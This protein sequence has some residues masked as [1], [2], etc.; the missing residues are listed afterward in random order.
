MN[1]RPGLFRL[2]MIGAAL[3]VIAVTSINY[4]GIKAEFDALALQGRSPKELFVPQ[5]CGRA[6]GIAGTDYTSK[7]EQPFDLWD[8]F[9]KANAFAICWFRMSKFRALYPEFDNIPDKD[10]SRKLYADHGIPTRD[11]PNPWASLGMV[12]G[13]AFGIPLMVLAFGASLVWA[14]SGLPSPG[15]KEWGPEGS[16]SDAG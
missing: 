5:L 4:S 2:W 10:V 1:W 3:F 8:E 14:S 13:V 6:R 16:N 7:Q 15:H 12:A 11:T 9:T